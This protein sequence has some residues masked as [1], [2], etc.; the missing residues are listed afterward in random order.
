MTLTEI[1]KEIL[2]EMLIKRRDG[3]RE[4]V[5]ASMMWPGRDRHALPGHLNTLKKNGYVETGWTV[6]T[7]ERS[8][9]RKKDGQP[10]IHR[11]RARTYKLTAKGVR[12]AKKVMGEQ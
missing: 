1:H 7:R 8:T 9:M 6:I 5:V 2:A 11:E 12:A 10:C 3:K 4:I